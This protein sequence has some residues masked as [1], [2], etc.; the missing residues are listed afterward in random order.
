MIDRI[1]NSP[2]E[3]LKV[4]DGA[5]RAAG[6]LQKDHVLALA[7]KG[8]VSCLTKHLET[9]IKKK[10]THVLSSQESN[11]KQNGTLTYWF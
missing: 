5:P 8:L 2:I 11:P 4:M 6:S 3:L 7:W 9:E 1:C 10:N